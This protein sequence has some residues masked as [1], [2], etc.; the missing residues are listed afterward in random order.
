MPSKSAAK[1]SVE[2]PTTVQE[3]APAEPKKIKENAKITSEAPP[4]TKKNHKTRAEEK[5]LPL[6]PLMRIQLLLEN[7]IGWK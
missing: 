5:Q 1:K 3:V 4:V 7:M 2:T 6:K